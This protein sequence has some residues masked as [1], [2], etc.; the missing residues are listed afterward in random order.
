MTQ[1]PTRAA[2]SSTEAALI[3]VQVALSS[4]QTDLSTVG[5]TEILQPTRE[6]DNGTCVSDCSD[7]RRRY[8]ECEPFCD[9][10]DVIER[11]GDDGSASSTS[12]SPLA[13]IR[14]ATLC[15][16][17]VFFCVAV[18]VHR[19]RSRRRG[20]VAL[21]QETQTNTAM[22][23]N[24]MYEGPLSYIEPQLFY[25]CAYGQIQS[26]SSGHGDEHCRSDI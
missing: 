9:A 18:A 22:F 1:L 3:F 23:V 13:L 14:G 25:G 20:S 10:A 8:V 5:N 11:S 16:L 15:T 6:C 19:Q 12:T 17:L 26:C 2:L 21:P 4:L 24:Q 7:L